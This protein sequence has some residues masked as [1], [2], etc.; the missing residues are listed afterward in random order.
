MDYSKPMLQVAVEKAASAPGGERVSFRQADVS[1]L[2]FPD[3]HFGCA[4]ISFA[5][6]N[7]TYKNPMAQ[8]YMAEILRVLRPGGRF[9]IVESCQPQSAF[10][11]FFF[12]LFLRWSVYPA[13]YI[14]SGNKSAYKYL[15]E[16]AEH[17]YSAE[18]AVEFLVHSGFRA[19]S[20]KRLFFGAAVVYVA[21]AW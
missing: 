15:A 13:G 11:R 20:F 14:I 17:F 3:S 12:R 2:P 18:E 16:S 8:Q 9:V 10:V 6:R 1:Q 19:V 5:F 4:G 7:L 21:T